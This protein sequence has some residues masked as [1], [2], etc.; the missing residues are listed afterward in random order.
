MPVHLGDVARPRLTE[1]RTLMPS[2]KI[3]ALEAQTIARY[4]E[5]VV[6]RGQTEADELV[7]IVQPLQRATRG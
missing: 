4:L 7:R 1:S 5:R 2:V 3:T 6:D